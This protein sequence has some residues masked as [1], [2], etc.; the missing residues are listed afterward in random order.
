MRT[1]SNVRFIPKVLDLTQRQDQLLPATAVEEP[2]SVQETVKTM[3]TNHHT[4]I[5]NSAAKVRKVRAKK[6]QAVGKPPSSKQRSKRTLNGPAGVP[7]PSVQPIGPTSILY[8]FDLTQRINQKL[9]MLEDRQKL[10]HIV[11][12]STGNNM[13]GDDYP[14]LHGWN[15][16]QTVPLEFPITPIALSHV[17][18]TASVAVYVPVTSV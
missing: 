2:Q 15:R 3:N 17:R 16:Q 14:S 7:V 18:E 12:A 11:H 5:A 9:R 8:Q 1:K 6:H 4:D 13:L 10:M